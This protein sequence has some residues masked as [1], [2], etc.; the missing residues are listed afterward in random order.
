MLVSVRSHPLDHDGLP[1]HLQRHGHLNV[2]ALLNRVPDPFTLMADFHAICAAIIALSVVCG[3]VGIMAGLALLAG[4]RSGRLFALVAGFL[5]LSNIPLRTT[6][7]IY[8]LV[9]FLPIRLAQ[10]HNRSEQ[11]A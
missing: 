4:N 1:V 8:T 6:L 5:S 2:C 11:A 3:I 9:V 7:G 10:L